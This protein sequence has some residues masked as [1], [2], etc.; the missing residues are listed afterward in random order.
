MNMDVGVGQLVD[1]LEQRGD[2][3]PF[4][5]GAFV[6]LEACE[7]LLR[8]A[9]KLDADDVRVTAEGSVV[10]AASAERADPDEAARSLLSV[11][12]R[13][14]VAAGPGVPP[15]LL[16]LI[17]ES[18]TG[19]AQ[20][21]LRHLHD[22]I[23][24]SLI[25][26]NR[27]ASRRVLAR[28]VRESDR[29]PAH[30]ESAIDPQELDAELD[31]LLADPAS[32]S[33]E[34]LPG[35]EPLVSSD[36]AV[37]AKITVP[38]AVTESARAAEPDTGSLVVSKEVRVASEPPPLPR[39][40]IGGASAEPVAM[41]EPH[42][43]AVTATVRVRF[44][45][46]EPV[47]AEVPVE[48][49]VAESGAHRVP[50][51]ASVAAIDSATA[52]TQLWPTPPPVEDRPGHTPPDRPIEPQASRQRASKKT[53]SLRP[54]LLLLGAAIGVYALGKAG[55]LER[56][57]PSASPAASEASP[58]TGTIEVTVT[59]ADAQIYGFVGRGPVV[60]E[61]LALAG[62]H[63]FVVFDQGLE[64]SRAV[65]PKDAAWA[66][67][68]NGARYELAVQA[69]PLDDLSEP[70]SLGT[71]LTTGSS[72]AGEPHGTVRVVT[73]PPGAKV[74]RFFGVGPTVEIPAASIHEGHEV[75]AYHPEHS[76]RRA[77]IG[78]SDWRVAPG[79]TQ[80][81]TSLELALPEL[82][83]AGVPD[84]LEN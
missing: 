33:L 83:S 30:E 65:V 67:T 16:E 47:S 43:E 9:V 7:G 62:P 84:L 71:P 11:L 21:D 6:A 39:A 69:R 27:G 48:K 26:I 77:I 57:A 73:N 10:V 58:Q 75:M 4:E 40:Q 53:P 49:A 82:Q 64:P 63:E 68:D 61:Q 81:T 31:E 2:R 50:S 12:S 18:M 24:A 44:P 37:T 70:R 14:L 19:E 20:R 80:H 22:A 59:P 28:L 3:L 25:P 78:P 35:S 42:D 66:T 51:Q 79:Q 17:R 56:F 72:G 38:E 29:P 45:V 8:Q 74:Y 60:V 23:E 32:R 52:T 41:P 36:E 5:I 1:E 34:P 46:T 13:L 15:H 55:V 54:W 76:A